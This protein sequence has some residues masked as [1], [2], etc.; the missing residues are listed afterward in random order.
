MINCILIFLY[1]DWT[2]TIFILKVS[3]PRVQCQE[4]ETEECIS[5]PYPTMEKIELERCGSELGKLECTETVLTLPKQVRI[6][7]T[8]L[9]QIR[10]F[11][12]LDLWGVPGVLSSIRPLLCS[13]YPLLRSFCSFLWCSRSFLRSSRRSFL[14]SSSLCCSNFLLWIRKPSLSLATF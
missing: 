1:W 12:L 11:F 4:V 3:L 8:R 9:N 10:F 5:L 6:S 2:M 7:L 13:S 14:W